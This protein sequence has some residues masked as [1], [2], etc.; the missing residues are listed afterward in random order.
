MI[1]DLL[2]RKR[3]HFVLWAPLAAAQSPALVIGRF[4]NTNPAALAGE[5]TLPLT[6]VGQASGL[7]E[8]AASAASLQAA[9]VYHY[10]FEVTD[11]KP[12]RP[13]G[14]RIRVTD[15]S[16]FIVDWRLRR[17]HCQPRTGMKTGSR[18]PLSGSTA[19]T[20]SPAIRAA[21]PPTWPTILRPTG[22][23]LIT[24][25]VIYEMPTAWTRIGPPAA[26]SNAASARSRMSWRWWSTRAEGANFSDLS[27]SARDA[28]IWR[29]G[30]QRYRIAASGRQC[31]LPRVGICHD[32][33]PCSGLRSWFSGREQSPT[34][35][36]DLTAL[37]VT[38][39][40]S[41]I[42]VLRRHGHGFLAPRP[43]RAH[44]LRTTSTFSIPASHQD[45]PD[46]LTS[47]RGFGRKEVRDG[48]GSTLIRYAQ[49]RRHLR[50]RHRPERFVSPGAAL[51]ADT[52]RAL[53]ARLPYRW[54]S[55]GQRGEC[56]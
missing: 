6:A 10:W 13:A 26:G 37:S 28:H 41:G 32:Q 25:L 5:R 18:R 55:H 22:C 21:R 9:T 20:W 4:L 36:R 16:A 19:P 49:V 23:R 46:A 14:Q 48:F 8:L 24:E 51:H 33:L 12:G 27:V 34:A 43:V 47:T 40:R 54:R 52:T 31:D 2:Q 53:D 29:S 3:T 11:R 45:D 7:W 15:P 35:H 17:P 44:R 50:S 1:A 56:L 30:H 42:R 39:H 38:C